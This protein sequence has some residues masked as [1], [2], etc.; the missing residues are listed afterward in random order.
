MGA[1]QDLAAAGVSIWLDDLDRDRL[2]SGGLVNLVDT[3]S[4]T[5]VTTNPSIFH[6]AISGDS[7]D[8]AD[9]L[10]DLAVRSVS[11]GEAVR[12]LTTADV[13]SACDVLRDVWE[14]TNGVDGRVSIEVDPRFARDTAATVAEARA[15][16]WAV[17]RPNALIKIPATAEGLPA[18]SQVLGEG[19]SVNVTLL[20]SP[21]RY[22][23]VLH[24]WLDGLDQAV[25][26]GID[27]ATI[28][29]VASVFVSRVDVEVDKRLNAIGTQEA[30]NL[31]GQAAIANSQLAFGEYLEVITSARWAQF[32]ARGV[33]PQRPLWASTGTKD[34]S[35]PDTKYV[36]GL[37]APGTVNTMP[38]ATMQAMAD[39]GHVDGDT[40]SGHMGQAA[41]VMDALRE[42]G[43]DMA[44]VYQQLEEEGVQKFID[45]WLALLDGI[46][47]A[48]QGKAGPAV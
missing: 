32:E 4:V 19:I 48:L 2:R 11:R 38:A 46:D 28:H 25:A 10:T 47:S 27:P 26:N 1:L 9:Q 34:P 16:H 20:F 12:S 45:A 8:Y 21:Q 35:Y 36:T 44:D 37:V 18:I 24:A 43:V 42:V 6:K 33:R 31:K 17:D 23:E 40:I 15:L 14:R 29:S 39:H 30:T 41:S 5:G 3:Q 22:R 7:N 13:R